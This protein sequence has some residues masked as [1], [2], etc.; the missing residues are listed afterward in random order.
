[1]IDLVKKNFSFVKLELSNSKTKNTVPRFEKT[2]FLNNP[3]DTHFSHPKNKPSIFNFNKFNRHIKKI[4]NKIVLNEFALI[5]EVNLLEC[6]CRYFEEIFKA[7]RP[8]VIFFVCYYYVMAMAIIKACKKL[9]IVSVDIQ[10]GKQGKY[11]GMYSYWTRIP[12]QGYELLP[13]FF[14]CWGDESKIN[15]EKSRRSTGSN[16][17][18]IVGGNRWLAS[19]IDGKAGIFE[20]NISKEFYT[21]LNNKKKKIL[22]SLQ[23]FDEQIPLPEHVI[24]A[25]RNSPTDWLWL[26][27]L[28]P[29]RRQDEGRINSLLTQK[30]IQ[31]FEIHHS[32]VC[33]LYSLL[34][35]A[36]HHITYYSSVCYEA[37]SF[38]VPTTII[39]PSGLTLYEEY[40]TKGIFNYADTIDTLVG[41]IEKTIEDKQLIEKIPYIETKKNVAEKALKIIVNKHNQLQEGL[42]FKKHNNLKEAESLNYLGKKRF[43]NKDIAGAIDALNESIRE[44]PEY[45]DSHNDLG[46]LYWQIGGADKSIYHFE[47]VL[48]I[49]SNNRNAVINYGLILASLNKK[50]EAQ[51]LFSKFLE[52]NPTD[53]QIIDLKNQIQI[54]KKSENNNIKTGYDALWKEKLNDP[55]QFGQR[56]ILQCDVNQGIKLLD[57][58]RE[59]YQKGKFNQ[60]FDIYEQLS[61]A[62]PNKAI[63]ILSE[64]YEQYMKLPSKD[65]YSLYQSRFYNFGIK[66]SDKVIDVGS[67]NIPF[68]LANHL[69]DITIEN[70]NYGRAGVAFK[71]VDGI[72]IYECNLEKL[73]FEDDEFDFVYCSHVLEHITDPDKACSELIRIGKRGF[74]ESPTRDKDIWLNTA[75]VSNHRWAI[76]KRDNRLIFTEYSP[77]EIEGLQN[78]VLMNMHVAP[79]TPREKAFS[80]LIYLKADKINTMLLWD[81]SFEFTINRRNKQFISNNENKNIHLNAPPKGLPKAN[82]QRGHKGQYNELWQKKLNDH[83]WLKND[84]KGRVEYCVNFLKTNFKFNGNT[85]LLDVGCGRG[86]LAGFLG[87][88]ISLYGV[89]IS[90]IAI[91]EAKKVYKR[92]DQIDLDQENLPY[93]NG[94]FDLAVVLDVIEHVFNP[95]SVIRKIQRALKNDGK[96][97]LSTPNIL[98]EK[99][100]KDFV[101]TR[102]FPKTSG[103][104]F[105][106]DGGHIHFFT[107]RDI[108]E[109][110]QEAG[111]RAKPIGLYKNRFD[112]EFKEST[113]W[114]LAEK[115]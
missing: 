100:L 57:Y 86:T 84:G 6:Y 103:D 33:P 93:D 32:T 36:D 92:A 98:Y 46:Y 68:H 31:N 27:R 102:K 4:A 113:V 17:I 19:W 74:I 58:G 30:G 91:A 107:Y 106:Y 109:L 114:I 8:K 67:G 3:I 95:L 70:D 48:E 66:A 16:H 85:K 43:Q 24:E 71:H 13:D 15:I 29:S 112:N 94:F 97:I 44:N 64:L 14:W 62:Y 73:P 7:I 78:D 35:I 81:G 69:V 61:I 38:G 77:E 63:E 75:K 60:A 11:H 10:H 2:I 49:E 88:K 12:S 104:S 53:G 5:E 110:M 9:G 40:I 54:K 59:I 18:P 99:Y 115:R 56:R 96:L 45:V 34:K 90:E 89:D 37:L 26:L 21:I 83:N 101:R 51:K 72:P 55:Q 87:S 105:P 52:T 76:E 108:F 1:M 23:P 22:I 47:K 79:Q 41:A 42:M 50:E 25:M 20:N 28:H 65:R 111:F 39:D 82:D 80:A